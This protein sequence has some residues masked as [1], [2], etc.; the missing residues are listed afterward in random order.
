[1]LSR[2]E[3]FEGL[4]EVLL[5]I[6]PSKKEIL[7]NVNED[8]RLVEDLG[9]MSISLLYLVIAVEEKFNV[10]FGDLNIDDFKTVGQTIDLIQG[11]T[12]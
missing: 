3:I 12:K 4:K 2:E 7:T 8:T 6:D 5:M 11:L 10:E 1:M 9:L